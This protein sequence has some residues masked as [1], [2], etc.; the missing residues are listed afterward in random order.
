M[1]TKRLIKVRSQFEYGFLKS[2]ELISVTPEFDIYADYRDYCVMAD[3]GYSTYVDDILWIDTRRQQN[4]KYGVRYK[5]SR[6][7]YK[8]YLEG[9][10]H[11]PDITVIDIGNKI[12]GEL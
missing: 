10:N 1:S 3:Y 11:N 4:T 5:I 9:W 12:I 8:K 2:F 7:T 6:D